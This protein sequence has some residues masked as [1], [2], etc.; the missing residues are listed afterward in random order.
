MAEVRS[1][2]N[3]WPNMGAST[4]FVQGERVTDKV[5]LEVVTAVLSGVVN[6]DLV[7]AIN[8]LGGRAVGISGVDGSLLQG[9]IKD[10]ELGYV[11]IVE[12]V[13]TGLLE[14]LLKAGY[15]P[16]ISSISLNTAEKPGRWAITVE[17]ECGYCG[18]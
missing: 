7:A 14:A 10:P 6:K 8:N 16:V 1:S 18:R 11:G 4:Q 3:G 13:N 15:M 9:R 12:K 2:P 17:C 5:G